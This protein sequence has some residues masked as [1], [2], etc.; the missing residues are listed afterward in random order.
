MS[1]EI[2]FSR[3]AYFIPDPTFEKAFFTYVTTSSN[4]V[5]PRTPK[6]LLFKAGYAY[7]II[8]EACRVGASVE[9]GCWKPRNRKSSPEAYIK[10]WRKKLKEARPFE[11]F[12]HEHPCAEI[13]IAVTKE[14]FQTYLNTPPANVNPAGWTK[15]RIQ[16]LT[17]QAFKE[18]RSFFNEKL[19]LFK[20]NLRT[21]QDVQKAAE[22]TALTKDVGL[23]YWQALRNC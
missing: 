5:N 18:D 7:E 1:H 15:E 14:A 2:E 19:L 16:E 13:E 20:F 9:S 8:G 23:L 21:Y 11:E 10:S 17:E 3:H 12:V 4:N 6:P 22:L